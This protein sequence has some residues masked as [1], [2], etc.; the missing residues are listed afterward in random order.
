MLFLSEVVYSRTYCASLL[1]R[2]APGE[3]PQRL[4]CQIQIWAAAAHGFSYAVLATRWQRKNTSPSWASVY[5]RWPSRLSAASN[6]SSSLW[7]S[8]DPA[9]KLDLLTV[10][11]EAFEKRHELSIQTRN[12]RFGNPLAAWWFGQGTQ[13]AQSA[14]IK[15]LQR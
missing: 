9:D 10:N 11:T 12:A 4:Q 1:P 3:L 8:F 13:I 5:E 7:S 2:A 15:P 6:I 14:R